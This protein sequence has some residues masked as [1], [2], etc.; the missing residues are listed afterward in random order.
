MNQRILLIE[1]STTLRHAASTVLGT[2]KHELTVASSFDSALQKVA[3]PDHHITTFD[4][5]V[6][7]WPGRTDPEAD[8]LLSLLEEPQNRQIAV[9]VLANEADT[10]KLNWVTKRERSALLL[11]DD[12]Q[13]IDDSLSA[14]VQS[15]QLTKKTNLTRK[16]QPVSV[17]ILFVDDSPTVRVS[18]RKLL[19]RHGYETDTASSVSEAMDMALE[20]HYDI[21]IVDYFMPG[22]TGDVLC[23]QLRDEP[24]TANV[25][26]AIITGT[27]LERA[28]TDSLEAGA[29]ECMF[30]NEATELF[31][32]RVDAMSRTVKG[33]RKIEKERNRLG[34]IL[35]SV[36][37]G[38][39]GLDDNGRISFVNP[40]ALHILGYSNTAELIGQSPYELFHHGNGKIPLEQCKLT[41]A[42]NEGIPLR[43][44]ETNFQHS[45]RK[46]VPVE[47]TILPMEID[48]KKEGSVVAFRDITD[49]KQ[50]E[51][52][53]KWQANH[54]GLTKLPNRGYFEQQL[55]NELKRLKRSEEYSALL[56][57]DL[58]RF[59]YLNDTAGHA[60]G[61]RLLIEVG[62]KLSSRLRSADFLARLGGDEF[63]IILRN[64]EPDFAFDVADGFRKVLE[65]SEFECS[66]KF[67][68]VG[69]TAGLNILDKNAL[70]S[71]DAMACADIACYIAK[72]KGRNQTHLYDRTQDGKA[73]MDM[74]LGW[75]ER[76]HKAIKNNEFLLYYQPILPLNAVDL[77]KLPIEEGELWQ[78]YCDS[79][80]GNSRYYEVLIRLPDYKRELIP[81]AAFVPTAERF[82]MMNQI[83]R[84]VIQRTIEYINNSNMD[85]NTVISI[86]LSAQTMEDHELTP[87]IEGLL[88]QHQVN[89]KQL[90]F[91][92]TETTAIGNMIA[93]QSLIHDLHKLGCRFS[94]DDFGS[95]YCSFSHLKNLPVDF[96]KIDGLFVQGLLNDPMDTAIIS[97]IVTIAHTVGKKTI[98]EYVDNPKTLK[99]LKDTG[100]D[101]V[102]GYYIRR[103]AL[104]P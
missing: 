64:I 58:D 23:R 95:G 20:N 11:W 16:R 15:R 31:L 41:R 84:W 101:Y 90:N 51:D 21:A 9:L 92:V 3:S 96:I 74:E 70:S 35:R 42:Y 4:A 79:P 54:D 71:C 72:G 50:L 82:N 53:L 24:R 52:E 89:P 30:K 66:G 97:S 57:L 5:I 34:G 62:R 38:V 83:D 32:A 7:G 61:D 77:D 33:V 2:R 29:I 100:V 8:E 14:L 102:Q 60:T 55:T 94:L 17:K 19:V 44:W 98:A 59:K 86:N 81:P 45:N 10:S 65:E 26:T 49:R 22:D 40:A 12:Y 80:N 75:S 68:K 6:F 25:S 43:S 103:P 76:L 46:S 13:E 36:G 88:K 73:A 93:A 1:L 87:F 37:D 28:I 78:Q 104:E 18:F 63:A 48:G 56:Y 67:Y 99:V 47:C 69:L 85:S 27:Y 91:E 39:Y